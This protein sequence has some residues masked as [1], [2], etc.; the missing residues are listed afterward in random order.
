MKTFLVL[1]MALAC[2]AA[3]AR[4]DEEIPT[5]DDPTVEPVV[6]PVDASAKAIAI[7]E[8][9]GVEP[10]VVEGLRASGKGWGEIQNSLAMAERIAA[11]SVGTDTP[12]TLA[13][14]LQQILDARAAGRG[15]GEIAQDYGFKLGEVVGNGKGGKPDGAE[16]IGK[17]E[18]AEKAEKPEKAEKAAKP[19]RPEKAER[20]EKGG[21]PDKPEKA[22][23]NRPEKPERA[24]KKS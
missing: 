20:A 2:G 6:E 7:A 1:V 12:L 16:G 8:Q 4:A 14:A 9:Y 10:A 17:A 18:K 21:R 15:Y 24:G 22:E 13:E 5:K 23:R 19:D 3:A 11:D